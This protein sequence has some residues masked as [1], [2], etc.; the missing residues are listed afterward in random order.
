MENVDELVELD[1]LNMS[2]VIEAAG[3]KFD[4]E[5]RRRKILLEEERGAVFITI[6]RSG[7]TVAYLE[8]MPE[9]ENTWKIAS[10]QIHPSHQN[11]FVLRDL[12]A[13]A[14]RDLRSR[15]PSS[16]RSSVHFTNQ[17]SLR[18]HRKLGFVKTSETED[19]ILFRIDGT[20]LSERLA[21]FRKTE[22]DR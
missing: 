11:G 8:Y 14:S 16:I 6:R 12:L 10:I 9:P 21:R 5:F 1:R 18:L 4:P 3:G 20:A 22:T 15:T 17:A 7:T 19:R 2:S 13:E